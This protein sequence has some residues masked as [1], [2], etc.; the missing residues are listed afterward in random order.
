M[1][2]DEDSERANEKTYL[3]IVLGI[4]LF[5]LFIWLSEILY[6][7]LKSYIDPRFCVALGGICVIL[8]YFSAIFF[9]KPSI[10]EVKRYSEKYDFIRIVWGLFFVLF[11]VIIYSASLMFTN[12]PSSDILGLY[13][14]FYLTGVALLFDGAWPGKQ[15]LKPIKSQQ[16]TISDEITKI[17]ENQTE[18]IDK[19]KVLSERVNKIDQ[20]VSEKH[21]CS[22]VRFKYR[23]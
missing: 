3:S 9:N 5:E 12:S 19:L 21:F 23:K 2:T 22:K 6:L 14:A 20:K 1:T 15:D 7:S 16:T 11:S 8:L 17:S 13:I 4:V 18:M 10:E